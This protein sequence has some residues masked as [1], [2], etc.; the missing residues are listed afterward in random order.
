MKKKLNTIPALLC[1]AALLAAQVIPVSAA[2]DSKAETAAKTINISVEE[3]EADD[4]SIDEADAEKAEKEAENKVKNEDGESEKTGNY[5]LERPDPSEMTQISI[6]SYEEWCDFARKCSYDIW[7]ADKYVV[8]TDDI[9]FN[10]KKIVPVPFFAGVFDGNGHTLNKAA[11]TDEQNYVGVFSKTSPAAVIRN[12]NV[13]GVAKPAG[14]PFDIGG[15]VG[16]NAGMIANCK[17]DGYVEGYDYIGGIAGYNEASGIISACT[18][19]GKITGLHYVGGICGANAGLV[20]GCS[21]SADINTVTKEVETGISDIKVEEV[22]TSLLNVGREEGNKKTIASTTNPVDIGGIVGHNFGEISSCTSDSSVGYEHV[23][24]NI[25]GIAGRSSGYVHDST[26]NGK[27]NG[28]KDVGGIVGQAEPYIRLDLT[29]DVIAQLNTAINSLHDSVEKTIKDTDASSGV[30]SARLNVIKS[31]ADNALSDT[32][33]L[34]N[35]TVDF[36]NGATGATNEI[37]DRIEYVMRES[38]AEGGPM[39]D[40]TS[41]GKNL[42]DAA[43]DVEK[44]AEDLDIYKY[45]TPAEKQ[46]YDDAKKAISDATAEYD[47]KRHYYETASD[48][49]IGAAKAAARALKR[50][51]AADEAKDKSLKALYDEKQPGG[52]AWDTLT[53]AE[54]TAF[55]DSLTAEEQAKVDEAAAAAGDAAVKAWAAGEA[56]TELGY[57]AIMADNAAII[58]GIVLEHSGEMADD[59]KGDGKS[60]AKDLKDMAENLKDA[61][62]QM[63]DIVKDVAGRGSVRFP[64]LSEEYRMRTNSLVANIQGMS[65]NLGFLNNEMKGSTDVVCADLESVND[66]FSSIMLLFTDA[67]DGVLDMDYSELYEDESDN[68]CETSVDATIADCT[69]TGN[70]YGDINTGGIAGTMAEEYD[71]DLEGDVTGVKDSAKNS[72]YR[73]KC[74]ARQN[75]NRGDIK[76]K[77][78]Y[79]GGVCG[80]AEIGTILRCENFAKAKS[81]SGDYVGGIAGRS[82]ATITDSY[83]K[84]VLEGQSYIGGIAGSGATITGCVAMP[85]I[86]GGTTF[87]GAIVGS[88]DDG[89]KLKNNVFVS[90]TLAGADRIS[91]AGQA[92]PV[93]YSQLLQMENIPADYSLLRVDFVVDG[94]IVSSEQ[95]RAGEVVTP[96]ETPMEDVIAKKEDDKKKTPADDGRIELA[97]DEYIKWDCDREIPVYEDTQIEGEIV[98]YVSSL[99]SEQVRENKQSVFLV[100]GRFVQGDEL[101]VSPLSGVAAG[102]E[103]YVIFIPDDGEPAHRI[104]YQMPEG[105]EKVRIFTGQDGAYEEVSCETY[106]KYLTFEAAGNKV[107][108]RIEEQTG[109]D[110]KKW[111]IIGA[112][113]AVVLIALISV[114][115]AVRRRNRKNAKKKQK[116]AEKKS[117]ADA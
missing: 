63:K 85:S 67:M 62:S 61:G 97:S 43:K 70:V 59:A 100:D 75:V 92:D 95:K 53:P 12:V 64:Q 54:K 7:S 48:A 55:Y 57:D 39:D 45:M 106:G 3:E 93:S 91:R 49:E 117:K 74:V 72:T 28:R 15:L 107:S 115:V 18:V 108:V 104:R 16:D 35:S 14:K 47:E 88:D 4:K 90:D 113:A 22:F 23:G 84:G 8:L 112:G 27:L 11:F 73:T 111:I 29:K 10:M 21:S 24:Y 36:V 17:F 41:A 89:A 9:D 96:S 1:V 13:I 26:N 94:K 105:V 101:T 77:K 83:E 33:Y 56:N 31:F 65:D 25:G 6:G 51:T 71:F 109:T 103:E 44:V 5:A 34:A 40:V 38:S 80:L 98:R 58:G 116:K 81:E 114:I 37:V 69:N 102:T 42:K 52:P 86:I 66:D 2:P 19:K 60:A 50:D 68:V 30:V 82:Y 20:T 76:G 46:S 110:C 78:S 87:L 79:V 99:A 32:G